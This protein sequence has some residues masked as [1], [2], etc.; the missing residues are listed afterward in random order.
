MLPLMAS[1]AS[2]VMFEVS[3]LEEGIVQLGCSSAEMFQ[4]KEVIEVLRLLTFSTI[5]CFLADRYFH[6][7]SGARLSATNGF[8]RFSINWLWCRRF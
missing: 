6:A 2:V 1:T 7:S 4:I 3:R 5:N 8:N